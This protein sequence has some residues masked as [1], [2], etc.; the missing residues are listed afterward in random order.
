MNKPVLKDS[1][2]REAA[3]KGTDEFLKAVTEAVKTAGG[4]ELTMEAMQRLTSEQ[5]TL[6]GYDILRGELMDGG[7]VQLIYNGYGPFFFENPFAK[8]MRLWGLHDFSKLL[9][10][11]K[12]LYDARKTDLTRERTDEEFMGMFEANPEFDDLDDEF[13]EEEE[14]ITAAIA[15]YVDEHLAEFVEVETD[16]STMATKEQ[17]GSL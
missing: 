14:N 16:S 13:V 7:F 11:A 10:K 9:Y 8:A 6:W 2:L 17:E 1:A 12:R 3:A 15:R 5:I 4:G